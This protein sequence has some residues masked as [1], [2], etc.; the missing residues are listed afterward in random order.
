V[1]VNVVFIKVILS[2]V[3]LFVLFVHRFV[4]VFVCVR[5]NAM[6]LSPP[7]IPPDGSINGVGIQCLVGVIVLTFV[8]E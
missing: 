3:C 5:G 1:R 8:G 6:Y 7:V 2:L 4:S